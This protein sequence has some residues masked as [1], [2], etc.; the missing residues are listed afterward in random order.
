MPQY[1]MV[2]FQS[3]ILVNEI[4]I[5]GKE[6][7]VFQWVKFSSQPGKASGIQLFHTALKL[8]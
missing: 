6:D 5:G 8:K 1:N 2:K 4:K 3:A 7:V